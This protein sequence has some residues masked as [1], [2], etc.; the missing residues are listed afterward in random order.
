MQSGP[1]VYGQGH[2]GLVEQDLQVGFCCV[3]VAAGVGGEG[4][5]CGDEVGIDVL[6]GVAGAVQVHE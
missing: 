2:D 3:W 4:V 6:L 5:P 1:L